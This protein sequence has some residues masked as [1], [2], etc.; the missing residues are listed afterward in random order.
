MLEFAQLEAVHGLDRQPVLISDFIHLIEQLHVQ[1]RLLY[2]FIER[3]I[4]KDVVPEC[5]RDRR[6]NPRSAGRAYRQHGPIIAFG[7]GRRHVR[8]QAR[9]RC[10][11]T[12]PAWMQIDLGSLSTVAGVVV[13]GRA[14][15]YNQFPTKYAF[16]HSLDA[17]DW[18]T[19]P[20]TYDGFY[21]EQRECR[22]PHNV[23]ARFVRI[24]P[25]EYVSYRSMRAGVL[26]S[27]G[28]HTVHLNDAGTVLTQDDDGVYRTE[29]S[30][31]LSEGVAIVVPAKTGHSLQIVSATYGHA[32]GRTDFTDTIRALMNADGL[33][34]QGGAH[35]ELGDPYPNIVKTFRM[36][37]RYVASVEGPVLRAETRLERG[38]LTVDGRRYL[39]DDLKP[40][41]YTITT[42]DGQPLGGHST[43]ELSA[44]GTLTAGGTWMCMS[45]RNP[46][47]MR[48]VR[49]SCM[50]R[51]PSTVSTV[52]RIPRSSSSS[53]FDRSIC[54]FFMGS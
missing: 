26:V 19:V 43:W 41:T 5:L 31:E 10:E 27:P 7:H 12:Y 4:E 29:I 48:R 51:T 34:I 17:S 32:G 36:T 52:S 14:D 18:T 45:A 33:N 35:T 40:Q 37:Y 28:T 38:V 30:R 21:Q 20:G 2:G 6:R 24:Y 54:T 9:A 8:A 22:F 15:G 11:S 46:D 47:P 23:Q 42:P 16:Q 39:P 53:S 50:S 49:S 44:D 1:A 25:L 13:V 3:Q